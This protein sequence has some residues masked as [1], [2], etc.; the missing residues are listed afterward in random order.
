MKKKPIVVTM[1]DPSGI[2]TEIVLKSWLNRKKEKLYPFFLVDNYERVKKVIRSLNLKIKLKKINNADEVQFCFSDCFPVYNIGKIINYQLSKPKKQNSKFIIESI[3]TSF[4]MVC[5]NQAVGMITL[6]VCKKTLKEYGFKFNGQTEFIGELSRQK[7]DR[8]SNE[9]M[10]L[11]TIKPEDKGKNLVVGL[12]TTH[13]PLNKIFKELS[14]SRLKQKIISFNDSLKKI[15]KIKKPLIG[16]TAINPHSGDGGIIGNE[17]EKLISP[18]IKKLKSQQLQLEGPLSSDSCFYKLAREKYDG[19]FC[20]YHD[21]ALIPVKTLDFFNSINVTGGIP[22]LRLS[23]DHGPAFDIAK[24]KIA[25]IDSFLSCVKFI[26]KF[27]K[28]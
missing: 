13:I 24:K 5:S 1:G 26:K 27:S 8:S 19:I 9:I 3:K 16:V 23:P 14:S 4:D 2:A 10:I 25:R 21:Q 7:I 20:L 11:S 28:S 18:L 12:A 6:P 22:I 17:E 15:W